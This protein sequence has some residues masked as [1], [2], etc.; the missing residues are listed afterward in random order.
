MKE[1]IVTGINGLLVM[2]LNI[3][4]FILS[5]GGLISSIILMENNVAIGVILIVISLVCMVIIVPLG[6]MGIKVVKPQE[7]LVLTLFGKYY[8]TVKQSGMFFVN[9][10]VAAFN[11]VSETTAQDAK[12]AKSTTLIP[13]KS[14]SLKMTTLNNDKQKVNDKIGNP[15]EIGVVVVW[16]VIDTALAVFAVDNYMDFISIQADSVLRNTVTLYPYD[17]ANENEL[18]L[19]G[20]SREISEDL[21]KDL[22]EQVKVA[23]IEIVEVKISH[24]A[25]AQEIAAAMLQRQQAAAIIDARKLIVEGA[26]GMVEMA[27]TSLSEQNIVELDDERKAAMVS[28]LLVVLCGNK[29]AQPIVNSGSL[30]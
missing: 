10:F 22:Q 27:L 15:I 11:P 28:N 25:Y 14:V 9:P 8:G 4:L 21:R 19:K 7:A 23:G 13:K 17:T 12:S 2:I 29:D 26:V 16:K 24:L 3:L 20:S 5:I 18:S 1:K 6:F 30:Y